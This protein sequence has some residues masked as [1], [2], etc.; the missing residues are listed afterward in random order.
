M[1][2]PI[3]RRVDDWRRTALD[4]AVSLVRVARDL[5]PLAE[6]AA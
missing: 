4:D 6:V 3:T 2:R 5:H 1:T